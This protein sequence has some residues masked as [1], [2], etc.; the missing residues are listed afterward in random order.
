MKRLIPACILALLI[1]GLLFIGPLPYHGD[2]VME[3][4][5]IRMVTMRLFQA[6]PPVAEETPAPEP[7]PDPAEPVE[8]TPELQPARSSS[9]V[10]RQPSPRVP[11]PSRPMASLPQIPPKKP[12]AKKS[13]GMKQ[14]GQDKA[15]VATID[16]ATPLYKTNPPPHYPLSAIRRGYSGT[17]ML[18]VLVDKHGRVK[19]VRIHHSS[20]YVILDKAALNAVQSWGFEPGRQGDTPIEMW[21]NV[22]VVFNLESS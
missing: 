1:H 9:L 2:R 10:K 17:V 21:V 8:E 12:M 16:E 15:N 19:A 3:P 18:R 11:R 4:P 14:T 5:K 13:D 6:A 7:E 22:P 20:G